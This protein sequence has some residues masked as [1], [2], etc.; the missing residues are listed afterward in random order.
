LGKHKHIASSLD[1]WL[2]H[3][4]PGVPNTAQQSAQICSTLTFQ[5]AT[6]AWSFIHC[7]GN[8]WM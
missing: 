8:E 2:A 4:T 6:T 7:E 3:T 1:C 5:N